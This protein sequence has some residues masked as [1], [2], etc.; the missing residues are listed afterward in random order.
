[1]LFE[2]NLVF[3]NFKNLGI[4]YLLIYPKLTFC[5]NKP[6]RLLPTMAEITKIKATIPKRALTSL[7]S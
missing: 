2:F 4:Y 3:I 1:M 5:W 6:N 7:I